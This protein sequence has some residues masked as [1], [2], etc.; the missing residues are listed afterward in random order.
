MDKKF[1]IEKKTEYNRS[2]SGRGINSM[3]VYYRLYDLR[4]GHSVKV[5]DYP[6]RRYAVAERE[7]L[8]NNSNES[9]K[10]A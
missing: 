9:G 3:I 8:E 1:L 5:A 7:R 10:T 4:S 6:K 2:R